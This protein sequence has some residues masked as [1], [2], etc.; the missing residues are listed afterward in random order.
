MTVQGGKSSDNLST[1]SGKDSLAFGSPSCPAAVYKGLRVDVY[2]V[3]KS[4]LTLTR[5]DLIEL[6]NVRISFVLSYS[7][8]FVYLFAY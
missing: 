7:H 8:S 1:T 6:I 4:E 2:T 3:N 5:S